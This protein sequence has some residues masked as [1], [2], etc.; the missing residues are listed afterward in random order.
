M[1]EIP[2]S[3]VRL[4]SSLLSLSVFLLTIPLFLVLPIPNDLGRAALSILIAWGVLLLAAF[5][6]PAT[7]VERFV[8]KSGL[9][10]NASISVLF[11]LVSSIFLPMSI[12]PW[13]V[14][15]LV[16]CF[17]WLLLPGEDFH[18]RLEE[19]FDRLLS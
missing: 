15:W 6:F 12:V 2:S 13:L 5:L 11:G 19:R 16:L 10:V 9:L 1:A 18:D 14:S 4:P 17:L 3:P 7:W 8:S